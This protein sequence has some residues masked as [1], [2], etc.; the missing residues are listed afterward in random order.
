MEIK[1]TDSDNNKT[2]SN[3]TTILGLTFKKLPIDGK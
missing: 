3:S 2:I 1:I